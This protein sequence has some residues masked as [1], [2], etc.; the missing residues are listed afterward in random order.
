MITKPVSLGVGIA[1]GVGSTLLM[2]AQLLD[3]KSARKAEEER[4]V[5]VMSDIEG[6]A[7]F[8]PMALALGAGV[9]T[10]LTRRSNTAGWTTVSLGAAGMLLSTSASTKIRAEDS[11]E[12]IRTMA[13]LGAIAGAGFALGAVDKVGAWHTLSECNAKRVGLFAVGMAAGMFAPDTAEWI[14]AVPSE[15]GNSMRIKDE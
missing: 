11:R 15:I 3:A 9:G 7:T 6:V 2:R 13:T 10:G 1:T 12:G 8:G 4:G 5:E 14:G